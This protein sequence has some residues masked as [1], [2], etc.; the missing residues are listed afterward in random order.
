MQR[1]P[2]P[3]LEWW[4][5]RHRPHG[6]AQ[7]EHQDTRTPVTVIT[8]ASAGIGYAFANQLAAQSQHIVLI[9]R[10]ETRL[11]TAAETLHE[12]HPNCTFSICPVDLTDDDALAKIESHLAMHNGYIDVLIN[13]AGLGLAGAFLDHDQTEIDRLVALNVSATLRLMRHVLPAML[14]RGRGG[15]ITVTSLGAL[16][17]GPYQAAYYASKAM[18]LSVSRAIAWETRGQGVRIC[19]VAPGPVDTQFHAQMGAE[20]ALYRSLLPALRAENVVKSALLGYALGR[21]LV[22]PGLVNKAMAVA[23]TLLPPSLVIP[24]IAVL[25]KPNPPDPQ[26]APTPNKP[27]D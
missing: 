26:T 16:I 27:P 21:S 25:L 2:M 13:N 9:A 1:N 11:R 12:T 22:V 18:V 10:D 14:S 23:L 7:P 6:A 8:G 19:A 4:L 15:I 5:R 3:I 24:L 17:P 20:T